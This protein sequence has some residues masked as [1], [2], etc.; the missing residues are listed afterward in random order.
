MLLQ[1][2]V[3]WLRASYAM[4]DAGK[5]WRMKDKRSGIVN[6]STLGACPLPVKRGINFGS[7]VH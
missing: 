3:A 4:Y 2:Q 6:E 7:S 5:P 1:D